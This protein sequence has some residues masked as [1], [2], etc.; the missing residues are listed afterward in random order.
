MEISQIAMLIVDDDVHDGVP[1][2][3]NTSSANGN[4]FSFQNLHQKGN[5]VYP[6]G[7]GRIND[8]TVLNSEFDSNGVTPFDVL[9]ASL[10]TW[11]SYKG[12]HCVYTI[13][14]HHEVKIA[15]AHRTLRPEPSRQPYS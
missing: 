12:I 11:H 10:R 14:A 2:L 13:S 4:K 15:D 9:F 7:F 5:R 8:L 1:H 3:P 6:F